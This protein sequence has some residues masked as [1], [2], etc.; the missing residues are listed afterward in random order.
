MRIRHC[1]PVLV[2]LGLFLLAGCV[3]VSPELVAQRVATVAAESSAT[4]AAHDAANSFAATGTS[5]PPSPPATPTLPATAAATNTA[6]ATATASPPATPT[7]T[8]A[9]TAT[10]TATATVPSTPAPTAT[11]TPTPTPTATATPTTLPTA[12]STQTLVPAPTVTV[13]PTVTTPATIPATATPV[14]AVTITASITATVAASATMTATSAAP[15]TVVTQ[16][17]ATPAAVATVTAGKQTINVRGGPGVQ[18]GIVGTLPAGQALGVIGTD[19]KRDWW[20]VCCVNGRPG[21]VSDGVVTFEGQRQAVPITPPLMPDQLQASWALHWQCYGQSCAQPECV[22]QST[23]QTGKV[24]DERWLEVKREATWPEK[25]GQPENWLS[26]VDRYTGQEPRST[27][28]PLFYIWMGANPGPE[29]RSVDLLGRKLSL[30]CTD[31]RTREVDAGQGW[32][33]AYEGDACYDRA[34][35]VLVT[36]QYTKRWLF[37]GSYQGKTYNKEYLGN[38]EVYQQILTGTNAP[39]SGK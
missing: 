2:S 38:Y 32:T 25:C 3:P 9:V 35:G 29:S 20:Q 4:A 10:A 15:A 18:F 37:T 30:W 26:Q 11:A 27:G 22:G 34:S 31:T 7:L 13:S 8:V 39:L 19:A 1:A 16:T 12:T 36:L 14:A 21:W 5:V 6:S 24:L 23:A 33:V 17:L 28:G